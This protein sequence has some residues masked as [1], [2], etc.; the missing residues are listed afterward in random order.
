MAR[1]VAQFGGFFSCFCDNYH[2]WYENTGKSGRK[3]SLATDILVPVPSYNLQNDRSFLAVKSLHYRD[4]SHKTCGCLRCN[5]Y[6]S[7]LRSS[8]YFLEVNKI[9]L[10]LVSKVSKFSE[11]TSGSKSFFLHMA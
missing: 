4:N 2:F 6:L 8:F 10:L 11:I 3:I 5:V 9:L 1:P 7:Y